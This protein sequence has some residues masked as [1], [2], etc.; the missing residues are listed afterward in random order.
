MDY[1]KDTMRDDKIPTFKIEGNLS[2]KKD[3]II[4][5]FYKL[6]YH[7]SPINKYVLTSGIII[8]IAGILRL[9]VNHGFKNRLIYG[10]SIRHQGL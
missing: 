10:L 6:W 9:F 4:M 3:N 8:T 5:S 1:T 2:M 7:K